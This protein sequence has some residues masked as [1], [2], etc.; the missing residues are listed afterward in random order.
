MYAKFAGNLG[1][2]MAKD[3]KKVLKGE[4]LVN[5]VAL[6]VIEI[7]NLA[8]IFGYISD[9]A[10]G[11]AGL[12]YF[13][14]FE[15]AAVTAFFT[16]MY[17]YYKKP[18]QL[19]YAAFVCYAVVFCIGTLGAHVDVAFAMM[20]PIVI[21][22]ILYYD[23]KL[24]L[25]MTYTFGAIVTADCFYIIFINKKLHSGVPI[26]SSH[27][28]M[29]FLA[30]I[31]FLATATVVTKISNQNNDDKI[32][33]IK[34][35]A[36]KV[37]ES[38]KEIDVELNLLNESSELA[39]EAMEDINLGIQNTA[40]AV[41]YQLV[42]TE[43][44]QDRL[45]NVQQAG[46]NISVNVGTTMAAVAEGQKDISKL[47]EQA[48]ESV[49]ISNKVTTDL[50]TLQECIDSMSAI[51][52]MIEN[53]AFQT[54]IMALNANVEAAR[55]GE[56]GKGFAVVASEISNMSKKTKGATNDIE[57]LIENST[58]SLSELSKSISEMAEVIN[59]EK[60]QTAETSKVFA[61]I[62][63]NTEEVK[64][65]VE[66]FMTHMAGLTEANRAI[67]S[68]VQTISASTEE[69]TALTTEALVKEQ[70]NAEAVE[71]I[72][73]QVAELAQ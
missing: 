52:K 71:S 58:K 11:T 59:A 5:K 53:I 28:L 66:G 12:V 56:A 32:N 55:A 50:G 62:N 54:N 20:F 35:V 15:V 24:I 34:A 37:N 73:R 8:L 65:H 40:E 38:I 57:E 16:V 39:K 23:Y 27:L 64:E 17:Y 31:I 1:Y 26:N 33:E 6:I 41:Q 43:A 13:I 69:V 49:R 19:K 46:Q 68:S 44:I 72:A 42:Q 2:A 7:I 25:A 47:V 3:G 29:E 21:I 10:T 30:S 22:F 63:K 4:A 61:N 67:V 60:K 36:A 18:V 14:V 70:S 48:D 9:F 51:T 45:E